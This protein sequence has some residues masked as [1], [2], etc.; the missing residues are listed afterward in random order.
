MVSVP[1]LG[2]RVGPYSLFK[3]SGSLITSC[4]PQKGT[5]FIPR[6]L[7]GLG[8]QGFSPVVFKFGH[9]AQRFRTDYC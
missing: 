7:L 3:G 4:K 1:L 6:F 5:L 9:R 2:A 8:V